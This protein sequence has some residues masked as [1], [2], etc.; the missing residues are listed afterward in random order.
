PMASWSPVPFVLGPLNGGLKWPAAFRNELAREGEWLTYLRSAY[1]ILP[2]RRATY[3][4]SA[5]I[6]AAFRHTLKDLPN[7]ARAKAINFPEVGID[8]KMFSRIAVRA[9]RSQ[10]T[11]LFVGRFVPY[12]L[13]DVVVR[14]FGGSRM[15]GH[16]LLMV[17]DGPERP[18]IERLI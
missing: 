5:A 7:D 15:L 13:P 12:K 3:R 2:Y 9:S 17:G 8:P 18:A 11:I 4:K 1:R 6:L 16:R 10:K 14:A